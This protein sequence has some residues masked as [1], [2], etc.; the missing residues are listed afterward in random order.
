VRAALESCDAPAQYVRSGPGTWIVIGGA[1]PIA[2][3]G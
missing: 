1:G 3:E 2:I